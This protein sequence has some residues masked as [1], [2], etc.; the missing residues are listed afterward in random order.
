MK[1]KFVLFSMLVLSELVTFSQRQSYSSINKKAIKTYEQA[2]NKFELR[3]FGEAL[4]LLDK[5]I[6]KD[7]SFLEA[8][9]VKS[10][11]FIQKGEY[12]KAISELEEGLKLNPDFMPFLHLDLAELYFKTE[13]YSK[14]K[15]PIL[16]L[17]EKVQP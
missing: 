17:F 5:V 7:P 3:Y 8:Y 2:L 14:G 6:K 9:G 12:F 15:D 4:P 1:F 10:T 13:Q 11:I 16:S